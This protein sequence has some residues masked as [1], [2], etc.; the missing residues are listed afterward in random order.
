MSPERNDFCESAS[1]L[2]AGCGSPNRYGTK[3]CMPELIN[4]VDGSFSG[5]KDAL[6]MTACPRAEKKSRYFCRI[7]LEFIIKVNS[8]LGGRE[9]NPD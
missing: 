7:N 6:G 3:G 9:S 2:P 4:R 1:L 8:W 5:N